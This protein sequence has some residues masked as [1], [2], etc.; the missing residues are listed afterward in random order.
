[1]NG[2]TWEGDSR[3]GDGVRGNGSDLWNYAARHVDGVIDSGAVDIAVGDE[4]DGMQ[5]GILRQD[6]VLREYFAQFNGRFSG[7]RTIED[8]YIGAHLGGIDAQ[9]GDFGD[10]IGQHLGVLVVDVQA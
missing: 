6:A 3:S 2:S 8:Q 1:M 9:T 10:G 5:R 7:L 4:A